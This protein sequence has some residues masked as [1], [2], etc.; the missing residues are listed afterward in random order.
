MAHDNINSRRR[1]VKEALKESGFISPKDRAILANK[2]NCS[3]SA[4]WSDIITIKHGSVNHVSKT[5]KEKIIKRDRSICY[6]CGIFTS[7]PI[8]EHKIPARVGGKATE[9]NLAVACNSCNMKK[10]FTD[11]IKYPDGG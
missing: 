5:L 9:E 8:I 3:P 6:I 7:N 10:S 11:A 4:I 1:S 2:F